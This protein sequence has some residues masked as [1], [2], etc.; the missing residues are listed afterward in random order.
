MNARGKSEC[1][2]ERAHFS[3]RRDA[4]DRS[5]IRATRDVTRRDFLREEKEGERLR[6][7]IRNESRCIA[8]M[9]NQG[10]TCSSLV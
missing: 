1:T 2:C 10:E 8:I 9:K 7:E 6:R 4:R 3:G 5:I